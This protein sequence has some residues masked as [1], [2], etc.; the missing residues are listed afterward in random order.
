MKKYAMVA[1]AAFFMLSTVLTA[2]NQA[3]PNHERVGKKEFKHEEKKMV[4]PEKKAEFMAKQLE[5]SDVD[6]AKVQSLFEKQEAKHKVQMEE[7]KK[8][9]EEQKAKFETD[10][11]VMET[12]LIKIIG[13]EKFQKLQAIQIDH[14]KKMNRSEKMQMMRKHRMNNDQQR[15]MKKEK[16]EDKKS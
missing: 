16:A 8:M 4:S 6:K 13:N 3:Q 7:M 9:R 14:L 1:L 12:D 2:Q 5:L 10:R 15:S 11:K